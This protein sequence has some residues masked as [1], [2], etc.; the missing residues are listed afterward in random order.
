MARW[1]AA[2]TRA[3]TA[4]PPTHSHPRDRDG[5]AQRVDGDELRGASDVISGV[6]DAR[7]GRTATYLIAAIRAPE[8][9]GTAVN[10]TS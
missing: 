8:P 9:V 10:V 1:S 5:A 3:P 4:A 2:A 6:Y 7:N